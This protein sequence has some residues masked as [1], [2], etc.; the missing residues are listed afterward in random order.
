[1]FERCFPALARL[2][3][4]VKFAPHIHT[5]TLIYARFASRGEIQYKKT[6]CVCTHTRNASMACCL[7]VD[8]VWSVDRSA[9]NNNTTGFRRLRRARFRCGLPTNYQLTSTTAHNRIIVLRTNDLQTE[10][11]FWCVDRPVGFFFGATFV[12]DEVVITSRQQ[13]KYRAGY[14]KF[15]WVRLLCVDISVRYQLTTTHYYSQTRRFRSNF[16]AV[17][18]AFIC[19]YKRSATI[20]RECVSCNWH[21]SAYNSSMLLAAQ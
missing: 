5:H 8:D 11:R 1:M 4:A 19:T 21:W 20:A 3:L 2:E 9:L 10:I 17:V 18:V 13:R 12:V 15:I 6:L 16:N 14:S 7:S